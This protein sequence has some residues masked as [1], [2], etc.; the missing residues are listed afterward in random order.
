MRDME[1]SH[2]A[3]LDFE[4]AFSAPGDCPDCGS[5]RLTGH[6]DG[7]KIYFTCQDCHAEW[8]IA[9]GQIMR[10]TTRRAIPEPR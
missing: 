10:V 5:S 2:R 9:F 6:D 8:R 1:P 4:P 7:D 3:A